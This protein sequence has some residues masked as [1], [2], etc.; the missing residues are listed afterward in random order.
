MKSGILIP[1]AGVIIGIISGSGVIQVVPSIIL[2]VSSFV[3]VPTFILMCWAGNHKLP[4]G[5][6]GATLVVFI[7]FGL[8]GFLSV[9]TNRFKLPKSSGEKVHLVGKI[10][11]SR[12]VTDKMEQVVIRPLQV[13]GDSVW[14]RSHGKLV[15]NTRPDAKVHFL[16]GDVWLF[17]PARITLVSSKP[18]PGGFVA[19]RYWRSRGV[20]FES[21]LYPRQCKRIRSCDHRH[22]KTILKT[23]QSRM[24]DRIERM[25][26]SDA[27]SGLLKAMLFGDRKDLDDSLTQTFSQAGIIHVL[28]VSGLH[29]GIVYWIVGSLL[30][31][32]NVL[33][34]Q[35]RT[36][37]C[38][39]M[40]WI[41]T[42]ISGLSPSACR[43]A[44]MVS[45]FG[46]AGLTGRSGT[47]LG[48]LGAAALLHCLIDPFVVFSAG[49]QLSYLAV[50][51]IFMWMPVIKSSIRGNTIKR[52]IL[53]AAGVSFSA[54]SLIIPVL[55]FWFG[56]F[57]L[58]FLAGNLALVPLLVLSFYAG[59]LLVGID[60]SGVPVDLP[61]QGL[62]FLIKAVI[63]AAEVLGSLPGNAFKP[64]GL[65]VSDMLIYYSLII[66]AWYYVKRPKA[67]LLKQFL[68]GT[69]LFLLIIL[70]FRQII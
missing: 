33:P 5:I 48:T 21:W 24:T 22:I 19:S 28:S 29:V 27:T 62:D 59:L 70:F 1:L 40:V 53:E 65:G 25:H 26:L 20:E 30:K 66:S 46:I 58:Y 61:G 11:E 35:A 6:S 12:R 14:Q 56:W 51:G 16:K 7:C 2:A 37:L 41:Y 36:V 9:A 32:L 18:S 34:R 42:G 39:A 60:A 47:G 15:I 3:L 4:G 49:A 57:P 17:G 44:G 31:L 55:L 52:K 63:R 38:L 43:A 8:T 54:Q 45:L 10:V 67:A 50:A 23:W 68:G 69:A 64:E 13:T